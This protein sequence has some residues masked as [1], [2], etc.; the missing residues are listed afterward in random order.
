MVINKLSAD[1]Q[2]SNEQDLVLKNAGYDVERLKN[3]RKLV[4]ITG[5]RR[6]N[7]GDGFINMCKAICDLKKMYADVDFVYPMHL[8]LMLENLFMKF[9]VKICVIYRI[10]F[11]LNLFN[12]WSLFI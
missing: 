4:L 9:S 10:C 3:G 5:H 1:K 8:I 6:E 2:L 7:F 11:L 12:I